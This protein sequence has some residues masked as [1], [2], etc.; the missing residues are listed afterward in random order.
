M[1]SWKKR[2]LH[3]FHHS[4]INGINTFVTPLYINV[5]EACKLMFFTTLKALIQRKN[6]LL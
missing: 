6:V 1:S 3:I 2:V 5:K 4:F